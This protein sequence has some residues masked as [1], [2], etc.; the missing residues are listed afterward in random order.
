[1][2]RTPRSLMIHDDDLALVTDLYQLTMAAA[3]FEHD[4]NRPATFE[5]F[6]RTMPKNRGFLLAAGLEQVVH[7]LSALRFTDSALRYLRELP[8]FRRV[9]SAFFDYLREFRFTGEVHAIPEGTIVFPGEPLVRITAPLIEAQIVETY[10]LATINY[11]TL[12]ATK[13]AR[14]VHAARGRP[15]VDFGTRRAHGPQAGVLAARAT[16]IGGCVATSN[17]FAG[18]ELGLPVVGTMA[19]SFMMTFPTE[20]EAFAA[21]VDSF[22]EHTTL[23][24]DTYDTLEGARLATEFGDR[25]LGVRIDS[26]DLLALS[27]EVRRILDEAGLNRTRIVASGDLNEYKIDALLREGAPIDLFGVGTELVTSRDEPTLSGVYK[28]VEHEVDGQPVPV[29]KLSSD[30]ETYPGRKQVFR[31][32]SPSGAFT[33]DLI[34]LAEEDQ[35]GTPLLEPIMRGGRL[36]QELPDLPTIQARARDQLQRLPEEYR[37]LSDP[38]PY[39]VRY[40][41]RL[42]ALKDQAEALAH[43]RQNGPATGS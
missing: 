1:M 4:R 18:Y 19:H 20:R 37:A 24:I 2:S 5:M 3:Y 32:E 11:Q 8:P 28:V 14:V 33:G 42:Q 35:P 30:K 17:V 9:S 26:G 36:V 7:Y 29:V 23:L 27:R 21:Y 12:V 6:I 15:V 13:A 34:A 22:P 16:Y 31:Q 38:P 40:S 43:Q 25:I 39:P 10:I 41:Q